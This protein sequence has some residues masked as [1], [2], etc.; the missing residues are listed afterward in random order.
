MFFIQP[1]LDENQ[2]QQIRQIIDQAQ[3]QDGRQTA[4]GGS[5]F[6]KRNLQIVAGQAAVSPAAELLRDTLMRHPKFRVLA[7][8][9]KVRP[10]TFNRYDEGMYYRDHMDHPIL[11][12]QPRLRG[13]LSITV[14]LNA[15]SEYDGGE[16]VIA[17]DSQGATSVKLDAGA[18]VVYSGATLHRVN[19]V[20]RG[21][22]LGAVTT[23]ESMIRDG[24]QREILGDMAQLLRFV[25]DQAPRS[26]EARRANKIY[27]NLMR[28][29]CDVE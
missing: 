13:D 2:L 20:T 1:L 10:F 25:Q 17:S 8:P 5:D 12:G 4:G 6:Q 14:F 28:R 11:P 19:T 18:A 22:R 21:S 9:K 7:Q 3:W 29:W 24:A 26:P 23:I 16:L 27:T 15:P